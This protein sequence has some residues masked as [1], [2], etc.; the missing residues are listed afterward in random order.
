MADSEAV[1]RWKN[2]TTGN[3]ANANADAT[4]EQPAGVNS[5][6]GSTAGWV[7]PTILLL[8]SAAGNFYQ[9]F[10]VLDL[11]NKYRTALRRGSPS[12]ARSMV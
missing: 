8:A 6:A 5:T 11:R 7:I 9:W 3:N 4:N 12:L 10:N 1:R 2:E